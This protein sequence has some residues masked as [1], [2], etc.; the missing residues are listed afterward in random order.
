MRRWMYI[1]F[2]IGFALIGGSISLLIA[3]EFSDIHQQSYD[4][5]AVLPNVLRALAFFGVPGGILAVGITA[6][7]RW[8][9]RNG[10]WQ[11]GKTEI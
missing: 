3:A 10:W 4:P 6:C 7:V 8:T 2:L 1:S 9:I 11:S 5:S